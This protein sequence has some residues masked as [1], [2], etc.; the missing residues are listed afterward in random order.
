MQE[1]ILPLALLREFGY[2]IKIVAQA[3]RLAK[4]VLDAH[5]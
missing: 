1:P 4:P 5:G 2:F 3:A